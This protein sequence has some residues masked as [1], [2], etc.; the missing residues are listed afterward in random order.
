MLET[1][2]QVFSCEYCEIFKDR[3]FIEDLWWLLLNLLSSAYKNLWLLQVDL[4]F[5]GYV[6]VN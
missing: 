3:V 6:V 5:Q 4:L 2:T 1:P